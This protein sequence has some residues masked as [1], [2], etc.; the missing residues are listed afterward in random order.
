MI[1]SKYETVCL[2]G[3]LFNSVQSDV[4]SGNSTDLLIFIFRPDAEENSLMQL[5]AFIVSKL[6]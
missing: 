6:F 5:T 3:I 1:T 2:M 4:L